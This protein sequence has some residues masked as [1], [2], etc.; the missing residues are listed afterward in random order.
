MVSQGYLILNYNM[1]PLTSI[2]YHVNSNFYLISFC[3]KQT[4]FSGGNLFSGI[5]TPKL[6]TTCHPVCC[7]T[8]QTYSKY[9]TTSLRS[10]RGGL[11][12]QIK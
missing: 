7:S 6:E 5:W 4:Y 8:F 9:I 11:I 12:E 10:L 1:A 3:R 2:P